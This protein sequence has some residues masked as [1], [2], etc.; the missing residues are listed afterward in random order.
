MIKKFLRLKVLFCTILCLSFIPTFVFAQQNQVKRDVCHVYIVDGAK[1]EKGIKTH[2]EK[3]Q[4]DSEIDFPPF[5]TTIGEEEETIKSYHIPKTKLFIFARV[6]YTDESTFGDSITLSI[7]I[8][9]KAKPSELSNTT[10]ALSEVSYDKNTKGIKTHVFIKLQN[11][12]YLVGLHCDCN[13][14]E[15]TIK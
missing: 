13:S 12:I 11:R 14:K 6:F 1:A 3:L 15:E 9:P 8:S 4:K 2:N 10:N 5:T 7:A